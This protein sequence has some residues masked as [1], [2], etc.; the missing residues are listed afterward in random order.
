LVDGLGAHGVQDPVSAAD[1]FGVGAG[2]KQG[3]QGV[4]QW[5]VEV[6]RAAGFG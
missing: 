1:Y 2:S 5:G 3:G 6:D 4:V